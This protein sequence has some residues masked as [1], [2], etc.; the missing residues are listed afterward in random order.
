MMNVNEVGQETTHLPK[1][2]GHRLSVAHTT[3][4]NDRFSSVS[5]HESQFRNIP[6]NTCI[7][8]LVLFQCMHHR[9]RSTLTHAAQV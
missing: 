6:I 8:G 5:V 3:N 2:Y 7:A 9:Y 1:A 4:L